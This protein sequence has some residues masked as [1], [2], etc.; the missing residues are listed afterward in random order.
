[1]KGDHPVSSEG[2]YVSVGGSHAQGLPSAKVSMYVY[3]DIFH[4]ATESHYIIQPISF[5]CEEFIACMNLY[6]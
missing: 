6:I 1:M 2:I 5:F 3:L 4:A